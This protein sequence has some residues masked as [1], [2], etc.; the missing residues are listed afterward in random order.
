M[1]KAWTS[2]VLSTVL[3]PPAHP[4][5]K[6]QHSLQSPQNPHLAAAAGLCP[7]RTAP[8]WMRSAFPTVLLVAV[9]HRTV[10]APERLLLL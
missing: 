4:P 10:S 9:L 2:I 1:I 6:G 7:H 3:P 5:P 8:P